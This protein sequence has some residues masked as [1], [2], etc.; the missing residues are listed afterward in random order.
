MAVMGAG[1]LAAPFT[2]GQ[3]LSVAVVLAGGLTAA[4][5]AV[6]LYERLQH[7]E[8]SAT[9][10]ILDASMIASSLLSSSVAIRALKHGPAVL[11]AGRTTKFL[12]W[13]NFAADGVMGLLIT[14]EGVEHLSAI[15]DRQDLSPEA[16][17]SEIVRVVTNLVMAG[18]MLAVSAGQLREFRVKV[19]G[20]LG[21]KLAGIS[22]DIVM[23][24]AMLDESTLKTLAPI[25]DTGALVKLAGALR[26]EPALINL[27]KTE[28]RLPALLGLMNGTSADEL[29][30]AM[31]RVNAHEAGATAANTE[32]LV[33][34]LRNAG[35]S[36]EEATTWGGNAFSKL[37]NNP[38]T[39]AELDKILPLLKSGKIIGV[40]KWLSFSGKKVGADAARTAGELRE[41][42]RQAAEN[43][44][45]IINL[46]G[47]AKAPP[48][49]ANPSQSLHSFDITIENGGAVERSVEISSV[50][51]PVTSGPQIQSGVSHAAEKVAGRQAAGQPIPG[52]HDATVQIS[53][54]K[55]WD[56][57]AGGNVVISPNGDRVLTTKRTP[58]D[59][60]PM[61]NIFDE[62]A[63]NLSKNKDYGAML[64]RVNV[65]D[66]N[67]GALLAKYDNVGGVWKRTK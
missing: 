34:F 16:K 38:N 18:M 7:A 22:D 57:K 2:R 39:L 63:E 6:S 3:S 43:P 58:P 24:L 23:A 11:L 35:I 15:F 14:Y 47:D 30:F 61:S 42:A 53:L 33:N 27:L 50:E 46:G 17:R 1:I 48:N 41:A 21:R 32:K 54:A 28:K 9:G 31:L 29:R 12:L 56:R 49:P 62:L 8:V 40:E 60:I 64:D 51:R 25:K 10:V 45:A 13:A 59:S 55:E 67:S 5:S 20:A 19:E 37:A 66:A 44:S 36:A 65:V 52:K 26:E 4:G